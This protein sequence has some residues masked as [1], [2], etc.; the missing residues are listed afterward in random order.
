MLF[1]K[2]LWDLL[3]K[4]KINYTKK[5]LL[6]AVVHFVIAFPNGDLELSGIRNNELSANE[7]SISIT[8]R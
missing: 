7:L 2:L 1:I 6:I 5:L 4:N 3:S 8:Q